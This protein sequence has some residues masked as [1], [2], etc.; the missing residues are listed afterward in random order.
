MKKSLLTI[1][2]L[3]VMMVASA[4]TDSTN[5]GKLGHILYL[6]TEVLKPLA[7]FT[8]EPNASYYDIQATVR[9]SN[10]WHATLTYGSQKIYLEESFTSAAND[11]IHIYSLRTGRAKHISAITLRHYPFSN[12]GKWID[13]FFVEGGYHIYI[14]DG[15]TL[16][17]MYNES[18]LKN[19]NELKIQLL[20]Q[21]PE[22]NIGVSQFFS[23]NLQGRKKRNVFFSP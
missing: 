7:L 19:H 22:L 1:F 13:Y 4:Q 10:Y 15:E 8:I 5:T 21:G 14:Y 9:L 6:K 18:L 17:L 2:L 12:T 20:R 16:T 23:R 3:M 11:S